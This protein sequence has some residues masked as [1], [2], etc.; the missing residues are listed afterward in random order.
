M[1]RFLTLFLLISLMLS[2]IAISLEGI[3]VPESPEHP[4]K[5]KRERPSHKTV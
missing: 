2:F 1:N 4:Q 3:P 5:I